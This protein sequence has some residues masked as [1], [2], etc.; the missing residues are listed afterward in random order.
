MQR[1][2]PSEYAP[3]YANY[4]ALVTETDIVATLAAQLDRFLT[5]F[6]PV[7]EAVG[8]VRHAPYTWSIKEVV[9]HLADAERVFGYR[10]MRIAR[11]DAT[12]LPGY[13]EN[14]FTAAGEFDRMPLADLVEEFETLRLGNLCLFRHLPDAAWT[15]L[16]TANG[17]PISVRALAWILVGHVRH[18]AAILRK[19][20]EG[21]AG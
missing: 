19:R 14:A 1:P 7:P 12:P 2:D 13:D 9:G 5:L 18:H 21:A 20:L 11:G 4:I 16:G 10:A 17:S 15:R 6:R 3:F 8:N